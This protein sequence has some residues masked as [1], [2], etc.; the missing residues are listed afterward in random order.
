VKNRVKPLPP[1]ARDDAAMI[2]RPEAWPCWPYLPLKRPSVLQPNGFPQLGFIVDMQDWRSTVIL[3]DFIR[4]HEAFQ[5]ACQE[6]CPGLVWF[7]QSKEFQTQ[8]YIDAL[9]VVADGWLV[10]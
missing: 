1:E 8:R 10:D 6:G 5:R 9:E 2:S 3:T 4:F 7:L